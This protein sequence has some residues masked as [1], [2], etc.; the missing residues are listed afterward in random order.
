MKN[1]L[2]S[3]QL[4]QN[5]V[6]SRFNLS[7]RKVEFKQNISKLLSGIKYEKCRINYDL[8]SDNFTMFIYFGKRNESI[9]DAIFTGNSNYYFGSMTELEKIE[10][11]KEQKD[12]LQQSCNRLSNFMIEDLIYYFGENWKD[13]V[14]INTF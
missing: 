4:P 11:I 10:V 7:E 8:H 3:P 12:Y 2:C 1:I 5:A 6:I 13:K 14:K 9:I